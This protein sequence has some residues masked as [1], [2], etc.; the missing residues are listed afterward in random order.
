M[1]VIG[2]LI[3]HFA[4]RPPQIPGIEIFAAEPLAETD[5]PLRNEAAQAD[6]PPARRP[7]PARLKISA[8]GSRDSAAQTQGQTRLA[9]AL[10]APVAD[11][12]ADS[13]RGEPA[14]A[15]AEPARASISVSG[16]RAESPDSPHA[17][18]APATSSRVATGDAATTASLVGAEGVADASTSL[19]SPSRPVPPGAPEE[20]TPSV[21]PV[22]ASKQSPGVIR[23]LTAME[24]P[25]SATPP[26]EPLPPPPVPSHSEGKAPGFDAE[27]P[28]QKEQPAPRP[29][30]PLPAVPGS[31]GRTDIILTSPREG[32]QLRPDDPPVVVVEGEV[33]DTSISTV[34]LVANRSRIDVPVHAGRF[35]RALPIL[36]SLVRL[37]VEAFVNG[38]TRESSTV[39]VHSTAGAQFGVIVF[40]W[41][42]AGDGPEVELSAIWRA[43]PERLDGP[44][45][46]A[47]MKAITGVDGRP[48]DAFY[49]RMLKPGVYTFVLRS[50]GVVETE[51]IRSTL[52]VPAAGAVARREL[53]PFSLS[54]V[55]RRVM[56]RVLLPYGVFWDQDEWFSGRSESVDTEMKF[57]FPEGISWVEGK[58]G[59]R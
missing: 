46:T 48:G 7:G 9:G 41:P 54:G 34:V 27:L 38:K 36:E 49:V 11:A 2:S 24:V 20:M 53:E 47:V 21:P 58:V 13:I 45:H 57:R 39:T 14:S 31:R 8:R 1:I 10:S 56:A 18:P 32:L 30:T 4:G 33:E 40:D 52:Y 35:R 16:D 17:E 44:T 43:T 55:G 15:S 28:T 26:L 5:Q 25:S 12:G 29:L 51:R 6:T 22:T 59:P 42:A 37:R 50:R 19:A 3:L 23:A